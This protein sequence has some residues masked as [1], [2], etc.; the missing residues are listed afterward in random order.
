MFWE[1]VREKDIPRI[2]REY[3]ISR[4]VFRALAE[5]SGKVAYP[6]QG[7]PKEKEEEEKVI[8]LRSLKFGEDRGARRVRAGPRE[9]KS[10]KLLKEHGFTMSLAAH[11]SAVLDVIRRLEESK[12]GLFIVR[13]ARIERLTRAVP[14]D[15]RY[16]NT[17]G[18]E[19]PVEV[20]LKVV[21]IEFPKLREGK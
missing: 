19:A 12:R 7:G 5:A 10:P 8:T 13:E 9:T 15:P 14:N 6:G 21:L 1:D 11:Y 3:A 17:S 4:E 18:H 2:L 20:E 16:A